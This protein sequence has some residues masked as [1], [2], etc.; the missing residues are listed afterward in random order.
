LFNKFF[1]IDPYFEGFSR[2]N[3]AE[4][5]RIGFKKYAKFE[6]ESG[7][8]SEAQKKERVIFNKY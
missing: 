1:K 7:E 5:S 6:R 3:I 4:I 2:K 8:V